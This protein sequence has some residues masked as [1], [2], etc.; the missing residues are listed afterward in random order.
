M[1]G[2]VARFAGLKPRLRNSLDHIYQANLY[3]K[4][5]KKYLV[6]RVL[7]TSR[8]RI[9]RNWLQT[10]VDAVVQSKAQ[11]SS[12]PCMALQTQQMMPGSGQPAALS[13]QSSSTSGC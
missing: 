12:V 8:K 10:E 6:Q 5:N 3:S 4:V 9:E 2:V 13:V 1:A 11:I 7:T